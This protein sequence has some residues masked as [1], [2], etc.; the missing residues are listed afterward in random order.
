MICFYDL[1]VC[2]GILFEKCIMYNV[3]F[4]IFIMYGEKYF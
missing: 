3:R 1:D 2:L 4:D